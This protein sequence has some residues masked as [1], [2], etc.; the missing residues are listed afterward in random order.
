MSQ[1]IQAFIDSGDRLIPWC[2]RSACNHHAPLDMIAL[3]DKL[4]PDHGS[5][6]DD[7]VPKLRCA[8]CGGKK[9]GLTRMPKGNNGRLPGSTNGND[10]R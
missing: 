3:R 2:H 10:R 7:I 8:R 5:L 4:G 1:T 6:H 9:I